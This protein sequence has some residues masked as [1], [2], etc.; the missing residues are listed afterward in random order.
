MPGF[1]IPSRRTDWI[2][3]AHLIKNRELIFI[4]SFIKELRGN[5]NQLAIQPQSHT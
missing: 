4:G 2:E 3:R 1:F 5:P